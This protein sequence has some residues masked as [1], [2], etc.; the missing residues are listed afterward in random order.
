MAEYPA[1]RDLEHHQEEIK[2]EKFFS[3]VTNDGCNG[4]V[5][6][7]IVSEVRLKFLWPEAYARNKSG[8]LEL[9]DE[10]TMAVPCFGPEYQED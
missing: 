3:I 8:V 7:G 6:C 4:I 1:D 9:D 2:K 5:F 10:R